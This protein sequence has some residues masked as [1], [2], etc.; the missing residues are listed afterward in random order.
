[1]RAASRGPIRPRAQPPMN[2]H[3]QPLS[4]LPDQGPQRSRGA[5]HVAFKA[6]GGRARLHRLEQAGSAKA[7]VLPGPE[8]V[9]LNTS[10]GLTAGDRLSFALT[11]P[12]DARVTATT[13]TAERAYR[14]EGA[15]ARMDIRAT[16]GPR[17][18]LDWLPQE[19]ILYTQ[20]ALERDT[21][22]DLGEGASCLMLEALI[23]GRAAMGEHVDRLHL[24]DTRLVRRAGAPLHLE[25]FALDAARLGPG[26]AGLD[27]ARAFAS[28]VLVAQGAED[29]LSP[30]RATLGMPGVRAAA[31]GFDGRLTV[32]L[33]AQDGWPLRQQVIAILNQLRPGALPRVWQM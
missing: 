13:Q 28:L 14:A 1:M 4:P 27:G 25:P 16:L 12:P 5:A 7:V 11:V 30:L 9:F 20:S 33:M 10:G 6:E 24:R 2:A 15:S 26:P 18:H 19:T 21:T 23:L 8:V 29:A 17:A 32:R 3:P 31:S 22:I